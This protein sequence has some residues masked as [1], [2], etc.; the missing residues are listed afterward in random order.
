M[1]K[2]HYR[3]FLGDRPSDPHPRTLLTLDQFEFREDI[4]KV[5]TKRKGRC[6]VG[7]RPAVG[8]PVRQK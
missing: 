7:C 3:Q 4:D 6:P 2:K 1:K 8:E 5:D